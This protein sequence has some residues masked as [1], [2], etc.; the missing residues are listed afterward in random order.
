MCLS[1]IVG[2]L[3]APTKAQI[4][5]FQIQA[6]ELKPAPIPLKTGTYIIQ[7]HD[8]KHD[9]KHDLIEIE[10]YNSQ[11]YWRYADN[12]NLEPFDED[13]IP[14][15]STFSTP[16][17]GK[18]II[19]PGAYMTQ[20]NTVCEILPHKG[21]CW[22]RGI[23]SSQIVKLDPL[24]AVNLRRLESDDD[25]PEFYIAFDPKSEVNTEL[26]EY[27]ESIGEDE[28]KEVIGEPPTNSEIEEFANSD[29]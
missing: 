9:G 25:T 22:V 14:L 8:E 26:S 24:D 16:D 20:H 17:Q 27:I 15:L 11:Y 3:G 6:T 4:E 12:A 10:K 18:Y 13:E 29:S 19:E 23:G 28:I 2:N 1:V 5:E 21:E 7:D